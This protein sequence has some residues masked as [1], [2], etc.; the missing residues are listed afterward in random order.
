LLIIVLLILFN[1]VLAEHPQI[2]SDFIAD[3]TIADYPPLEVKFKDNSIDTNDW[4][5]DF[6]DNFT[7]IL[8]NP[9]HTYMSNGSFTVIHNTSNKD[10]TSQTIKINYI[11]IIG[12]NGYQWDIEDILKFEEN[13]KLIGNVFILLSIVLI[14][15]SFFIIMMGIRGELRSE[16]V[17]VMI[18]QIIIASVL[19][20]IGINISSGII[21]I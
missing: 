11:N 12:G 17:I 2:T 10:G 14:I 18:T 1:P 3:I 8:K 20:L 13:I 21:G 7:S 19:L 4:Y 6:G 15:V 16:V 9:H 5:W